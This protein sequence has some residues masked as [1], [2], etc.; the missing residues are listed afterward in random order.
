MRMFVEFIEKVCSAAKRSP[1]DALMWA[2]LGSFLLI[3]L[4]TVILAIKL[5]AVRG[6]CKRPFLC[7]VN[8]Y[9]AAVL[10]AFLSETQ[11]LSALVAAALFWMAGYVMYGALCLIRVK[12]QPAPVAYAAVT[13]AAPPAPANPKMQVRGDIPAAKNSVRLEHAMGVTDRLLSKNLGKSDR[14]ELEK[15]KNTLAVLQLKGTLSPPEAEIL[16]E[17]FNTLLKLMAKYNV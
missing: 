14:Q 15:L 16:N 8:L 7:L 2:L 11:S 1:F 3:Y 5:P 17:N 9:A 10:V 6:A 13:P 4:A 12:K